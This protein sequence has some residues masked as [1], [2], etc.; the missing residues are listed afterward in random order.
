MGEPEFAAES[1]LRGRKAG[2]GEELFVDDDKEAFGARKDHAAGVLEFGLVEELATFSAE[3]A[4]DEDERL[5]E[6]GGAQI[7]DLHVAGHGE[8]VE[9]AVE[10]AHGLV[11]DSGDNAAVDMSRWAFVHSVELEVGG[12]G[13]GFGVGGVGGEDEVKA[14]GIGGAAAE[15]V[16]GALVY[17]S[18]VASAGSS[19]EV[20]GVA[21][22][23]GSGHGF[24]FGR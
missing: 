11:E 7:V 1:G 5:V 20:R 15:A 4:A 6:R 8:D 12:G 19:E 10:L 2:G 3:M 16:I 13:D 22:G 23:V 21:S 24:A 9:R 18:A 14:L 17:G